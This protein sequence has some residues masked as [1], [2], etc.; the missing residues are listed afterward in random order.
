V[1]NPLRRKIYGIRSN[2]HEER[3]S[4]VQ[5]VSGWCLGCV[6]STSLV[7]LATNF[8]KR[9]F[10]AIHGAHC[11]AIPM[12]H[13][14][15]SVSSVYRRWPCESGAPRVFATG[16]TNAHGFRHTESIQ[17]RLH[18]S[19]DKTRCPSVFADYVLG[20]DGCSSGFFSSPVLADNICLELPGQPL[21][22]TVLGSHTHVLGVVGFI[23][24]H[25]LAVVTMHCT[26]TTETS[27]SSLLRITNLHKAS[28]L[29]PRGGFFLGEPD[30]CTYPPTAAAALTP[31]RPGSNRWLSGASSAETHNPN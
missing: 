27:L 19:T 20:T 8:P 12:G 4:A 28:P 23:H 21:A 22:T 3:P 17:P 6:C 2:Q 25:H 26:R 7:A 14:S 13:H 9:V 16:R 11:V 24:N 5:S 15:H 10:L 18:G 31:V 1:L 30:T 29:L